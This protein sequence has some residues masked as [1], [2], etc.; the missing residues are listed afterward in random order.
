MEKKKYNS[1]DVAIFIFYALFGIFMFFVPVTI[2][3][4]KSIPIDHITTLV[5]KLPNYNLIFGVF[6]VLAGI[7]YAIKTKSWQKSKLHS[8]FF[9]IK[10][11]ALVF[12][13]MFV[14]NKGPARIFDGD[15][16]P[17]IW[18]GIMVSVA[19]IVP[20]GSVFLAFLT[21]FGLMEFI[22][23]FMEPVMRP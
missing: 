10:L 8:V 1:K 4:A 18:N 19:T 2:G 21:G 5:K 14:T 3:G 15:M 9:A 13:F 16:L 6:M 12:V 17:L 11:V 23:V 22:G 20:I 7:A